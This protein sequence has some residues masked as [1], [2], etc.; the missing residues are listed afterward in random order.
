MNDSWDETE[1][2]ILK[3]WY[4]AGGVK[5]I[6]GILGKTPGS[7][8]AK[9]QRM[10]LHAKKSQCAESGLQ[11]LNRAILPDESDLLRQLD[12]TCYQA[13]PTR[14]LPHVKKTNHESERFHPSLCLTSRIGSLT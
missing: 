4:S 6:A 2:E 5:S 9:A 11:R 8:R 14:H 3:L 13:V 7:V 1:E 12:C 10:G